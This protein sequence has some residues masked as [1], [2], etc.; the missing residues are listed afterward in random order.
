M[1]K[2]SKIRKFI[3]KLQGLPDSQKKIIIFSVAIV[4]A[5]I[6][7]FFWIKSS[8]DRISK[9][10]ESFQS[11]DLPKIDMP[12]SVDN[13]ASPSPTNTGTQVQTAN[14]KTY[15]NNALGIEFHYP[16]NILSTET[17]EKFLS[18]EYPGWELMVNILSPSAS[19]GN[20]QDLQKYLLDGKNTVA[21]VSQEEVL[22]GDIKST[23]ISYEDFGLKPPA[24]PDEF[25]VEIFTP[26]IDHSMEITFENYIPKDKESSLSDLNAILSTFKF[27]K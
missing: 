17:Q 24:F 22:L 12:G 27:T 19:K 6:M 21:N 3:L 2:E 5:L 26:V 20:L 1:E 11:M 7:G 13:N 25:I 9:V 4:A 18:M 10:G 14:W 8:A 15:T 23:K 16:G